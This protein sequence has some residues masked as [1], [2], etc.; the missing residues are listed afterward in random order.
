MKKIIKKLLQFLQE[1]NGQLSNSRLL[2]FLAVVSFIIDWQSHI[3]SHIEFNPSITIIGF[4]LGV[5]GL[6]VTQYF[7]EVKS[8]KSS[9]YKSENNC[10]GGLNEQR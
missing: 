9:D 1:D 4:V 3:W 5:V 10:K 6:K 8:D 2:A 7:A